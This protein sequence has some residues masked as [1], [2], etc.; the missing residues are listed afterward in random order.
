MKK[1]LLLFSLLL[2]VAAPVFAASGTINLVYS[3]G[4]ITEANGIAYYEFDIQAYLSEGNEVLGAGMAYIE[5]PISVFGEILI[6]N[7]KVEVS[8]TG[9][10]AGTIPNIAIYLYDIYENDTYADVF[11]IT[12][13]S[14]TN[15][16]DLKQY[17]TELSNDP[18]APSDLLHIKMEIANYGVG[19]VLF[20]AYIPG[21]DNLY[22]NF[23]N[24]TFSGGLNISEAIE[25]VVYEDPTPDP[26]GS[27]TW[28]SM[29]AAWKKNVIELKWSTKD[30]VDIVG[31]VVKRSTNGG[32]PVEV[33]SYLTDPTLIAQGLVVSKYEIND[34][35][36][37]ASNAY[38]YCIEA[39]DLVGAVIS[40][41]PVDVINEAVV[42]ASYPNPFNP[43]FVVPFELFTAQNVNV[44]LYDMT[45]RVVRNIASGNHSA[46]HYEYRVN[47]DNLSSGVYLLRTVIDDVAN[48]Q[49][50]L[51]V[52]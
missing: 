44:K 21:S 37:T 5:Y 1:L 10:L 12:F 31:Y 38:S 14:F 48:T 20:P 49:K 15:Q 52:K 19:N 42:E 28:K 34:A 25:P 23:E 40:S 29:D 2:I 9:I 51:L 3:N 43:S 32:E 22:Y 46:G 4:Q 18:L 36:V 39:V 7:D 45:G 41:T 27:L 6:S 30:E 26:V 13:E 8:K 24:E 47:C 17:F 16:A 11:A 35:D 33:A 50:M